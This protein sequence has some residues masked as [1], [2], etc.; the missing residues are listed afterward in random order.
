MVQVFGEFRALRSRLGLGEA[1]YAC[2]RTLAFR[3]WAYSGKS[4][5][6]TENPYR[7]PI[8]PPTARVKHIAM[9]RGL[10]CFPAKHLVHHSITSVG[11]RPLLPT[12]HR[13]MVVLS[14]A[15]LSVYDDVIN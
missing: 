12:W 14:G 3:F 6:L 10:A 15:Y 2:M 7:N 4:A 13:S 1:F 8:D 5:K 11:C 9:Q